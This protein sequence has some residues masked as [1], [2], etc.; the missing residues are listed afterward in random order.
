MV[1]RIKSWNWGHKKLKNKFG[2]E[3]TFV[4]GHKYDSKFEAQYAAELALRKKAGDIKDWH[5]HESIDLRVNG[6]L[7][8]TYKIDFVVEHNDGS[9]EYV[10]TKG[11]E[12]ADWRL[13][14]KLFEALYSG[15]PG[16]YLTVVKK[17]L[18]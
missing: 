16:V 2:A 8:A 11:F 6:H 14:W 15:I 7:V 12:T 5:A 13:K 9:T 10:E 4:N 17:S 18:R 3:T 1:F